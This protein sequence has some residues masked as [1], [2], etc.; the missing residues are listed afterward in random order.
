MPRCWPSLFRA[1]LA[2]ALAL[3]VLTAA[4]GATRRLTTIEA[5]RQFPGFYH[6]QNVLLRGEFADDG[7]RLLLRAD[8]QQLR[9]MLADGVSS[10]TGPVEVRGQMIDIGKLDPGDPRAGG[11][12]EDRE[13]ERWPRPGEELVVRVTDVRSADSTGTASIRSVSLE[14]WRYQGQKVTL[15]GNFRGRNLF[16]DLPGAP[17]KSRYDFVIRGSEGAI[18]VTGQRPRGKGFDLDV[19]RR[20]DSDRW[21]EVTGTI[22]HERGLVLLEAAQLAAATAPAAEPPPEPDVPASPPPPIEVV[23]SS[24]TPDEIDVTPASPVRIQFSRGL[25]PKSVAGAFRVAYVGV[26]ASAA[27]PVPPFETTYDAAN[28]AITLRFK[29]P[30]ERFRTVRI[31]VLDTLKAFDGAPTKPWTL[32]FSVGG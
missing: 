7:Q 21:L 3:P 11:F 29:E 23:F 6:L 16:G 14:P 2:V 31:D 26:P 1:C 18:W 10:A 4:Q 19:D 15:L 25:D 30:L 17:G 22:V 27:T 13:A 5:L 32:T 20:F 12:I 9:V 8:E 24:P 28:R